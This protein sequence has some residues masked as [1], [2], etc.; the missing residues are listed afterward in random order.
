MKTSYLLKNRISAFLILALAILPSLLVAQEFIYKDF[1]Y[2]GYTWE[3]DPELYVVNDSLKDEDAIFTMY[4]LMIDFNPELQTT[5]QQY[6]VEHYK[7]YVN[8]D[9]AIEKVNKIYIPQENPNDKHNDIK[10]RVIQPDGSIRLIDQDNV[11]TGVH[12]E[13]ETEYSYY[14]IEGLQKG[15]EVE[16]ILKTQVNPSLYGRQ[17]FIQKENPVFNYHFEFIVPGHLEYAFKTYNTD[18][19]IEKNV[20]DGSTV[21]FLDVPYIA[22]YKTE[23]L[24]NSGSNKEYFVFKLDKNN[25]QGNYDVNSFGYFSKVVGERGLNKKV[26]KSAAK[27]ISKSFKK[28]G[29][30]AND[31]DLVKAVKVENYIKQNF[32]FIDNFNEESLENLE[33]IF[34]QNAI[35]KFGSVQLYSEYLKAAGLSCQ[36]VVTCDKSAV[37][38]DE[39]F[40]NYLLLDHYL[41][42]IPELDMVLNPSDM[43]SRLQ[44]FNTNYQGHPG[45]FV[46]T[47]KIGSTTTAM[48]KV[49]MIPTTTGSENLT[50]AVINVNILE[51]FEDIEINVVSE[52][53]G[54]MAKQ[55]QPLFPNV[56]EEFKEDFYRYVM[57][58]YT[59]QVIMN[60]LKFENVEALDF[61]LKPMRSIC[62]IENEDFWQ[63]AGNNYILNAGALIGPQSQMY[64]DG[65]EARRT[66]INNNHARR[67]QYEISFNI[68][69]N[70]EVSNLEDL[71]MD[72]DGSN[73]DYRYYFKS[74]YT[75]DGNKVVVIVDEL[76]DHDYYDADQ[77]PAYQRVIN[78]AADFSKI[79]I[80]FKPK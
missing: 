47:R 65:D 70:Y 17:Y 78:A 11:K 14:A 33:D 74:S 3:E 41:I 56:E 58:T 59:D 16:V 20:V 26:S 66:P 2:Q 77:F 22:K 42:Y 40:E 69:D 72:I 32:A 10:I 23:K 4:K 71:N 50:K 37:I 60:T 1:K 76:Y 57:Y 5:S 27:S 15:S 44:Y 48:G 6:N 63:K 35:N 19:R 18:K 21:H 75:M 31:T 24:S 28:I 49:G 62:S 34:K 79:K 55:F 67:F 30:D 8:S 7:Y 38:F 68:L 64:N 12:E 46:K 43:Y 51:D 53:T 36:L 25:A 29:I 80:I 13:S 61:P 73:G 54:H 52:R 9:K 39:D 45:L